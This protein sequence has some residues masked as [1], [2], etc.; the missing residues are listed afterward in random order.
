[1]S[2]RF[3]RTQAAEIVMPALVDAHELLRLMRGKHKDILD[4]IRAKKQIAPETETQLKTIVEE[5]V[6]SF[7]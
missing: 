2:S 7:A 4:E 6:K 1:M 3:D 5:F